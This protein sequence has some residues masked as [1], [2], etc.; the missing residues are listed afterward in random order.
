MREKN[1][2]VSLYY[3]VR[4]N[5]NWHLI[6]ENVIAIIVNVKSFL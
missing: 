6:T 4:L 3:A 2:K 5:Y 1:G